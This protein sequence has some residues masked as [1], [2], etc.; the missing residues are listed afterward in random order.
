[1]WLDLKKAVG[2]NNET[3]KKMKD[4]DIFAILEQ[5]VAVQGPL[6][7][8]HDTQ[9]KKKLTERLAKFIS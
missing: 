4:E 7:V 1:M 5:R 3:T 8:C 9:K 6:E 2:W